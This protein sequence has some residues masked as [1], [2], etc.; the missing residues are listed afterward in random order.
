MFTYSVCL[1]MRKFHVICMTDFAVFCL[2]QIIQQNRLAR[3][4]LSAHLFGYKGNQRLYS[5]DF[6][7]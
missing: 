6:F 4:S 2:F 3:S 1:C 7:K 5:Q